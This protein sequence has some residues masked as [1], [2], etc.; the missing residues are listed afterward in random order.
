MRL[1]GQGSLTCIFNISQDM[2]R[3]FQA[4]MDEVSF[5]LVSQTGQGFLNGRVE[6]DLNIL[7]CHLTT[8]C[9][10]LSTLLIE[11]LSLSQ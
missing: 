2:I 7:A 4:S 11:S 1:E 10:N 6:I 5:S 8:G 9:S 3:Y